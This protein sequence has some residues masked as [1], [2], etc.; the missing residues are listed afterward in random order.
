MNN[1]FNILNKYTARET[2]KLQKICDPLNSYF[3]VT[4][5]WYSKTDANG[6]FFTI[7]NRPE[8]HENY[9][10]SEGYLVNPFFRNP[11]L[12]RSGIYD[13]RD[14]QSKNHKE[15]MENLSSEMNIMLG[16]AIVVQKD[17]TIERFG[18]AGNTKTDFFTRL[19]DSLPLLDKFNNYFTKEISPII[20]NIENDLV[21]LPELL[22]STFNKPFQNPRQML[23]QFEKAQFLDTIG[24]LKMK[25]INLLTARELDCLEYLHLGFSA[26][27]TGAKLFL[28]PRTIESHLDS[29]KRKL[30][31][32]GKT[33]LHQIASV[34]NS[35]SFFKR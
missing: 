17:N 2:K 7:A 14:I 1:L 9:F 6:N 8:M 16:L 25:E 10:G 22:G 24:V 23:T 29:A 18:Y 5:F 12:I 35:A 31:C 34:L 20:K 3:G 4:D 19:V 21:S 32:F 28:S 11:K 30:N 15:L 26:R 27:Q 13:Y 33:Q